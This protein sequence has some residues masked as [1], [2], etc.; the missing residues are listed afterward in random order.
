MGII[1]IAI[2]ILA[3]IFG[4]ALLTVFDLATVGIGIG[5]ILAVVSMI[6]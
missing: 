5:I 1:K 4:G 6:I 2:I 3:V